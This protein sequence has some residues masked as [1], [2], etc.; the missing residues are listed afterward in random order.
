MSPRVRLLFFFFWTLLGL[1]RLASGGMSREPLGRND[2]FR[3]PAARPQ[4][5]RLAEG[6]NVADAETFFFSA[7]LPRELVQFQTRSGNWVRPFEWLIAVTA[8]EPETA[9]RTE[10]LRTRPVTPPLTKS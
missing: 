10:R 2:D 9:L 7:D 5:R 1:H 6:L 4:G 3:R 8:T